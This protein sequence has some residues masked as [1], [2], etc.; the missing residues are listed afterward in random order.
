[1]QG[2]LQIATVKSPYGD[3]GFQLTGMQIEPYKDE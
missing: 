2:K 1:V 3:V